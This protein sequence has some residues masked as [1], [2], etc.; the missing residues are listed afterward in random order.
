MTA[1]QYVLLLS[2]RDIRQ[3]YNYGEAPTQLHVCNCEGL[4]CRDVDAS[5]AGDCE[6]TSG[7]RSHPM[8]EDDPDVDIMTREE[9]PAC[10]HMAVDDP[11]DGGNDVIS[12]SETSKQEEEEVASGM[13]WAWGAD[14][15]DDDQ[16]DNVDQDRSLLL[17]AIQKHKRSAEPDPENSEMQLF[18]SSVSHG[19]SWKHL[20]GS[21]CYCPYTHLSFLHRRASEQRW[22]AY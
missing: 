11:S 20:S 13:E 19:R 9:S 18:V 22:S 17:S 7:P 14:T 3:V 10:D 21:F 16:C 8:S 2:I 1:S 12:D 6:R 5:S 15:L 4:Y